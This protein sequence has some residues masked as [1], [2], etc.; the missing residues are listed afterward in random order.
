MN[1]REVAEYLRLKERKIYDLVA[2][3]RI[4]CTRAAGKWLFPRELID[5]WL[6]QQAEGVPEPAAVTDPPPIVGGSHDPLLEWAVRE[7]GSGLAV[8]FDGSLDGLERLLR[9]EVS[10]CGLHVPDPEG[11]GHNSALLDQRAATEPLVAIEWARRW[12]GLIVAPGNPL[13]IR[14]LTD[15]A[16]RRFALRQREAGSHLLLDRLLREA[17]LSKAD[18]SACVGPLRSETELARAIAAG[19]ADAG[20]GIGAAARPLALDFIPLV[21][22]RYDLLIWR[23]QYFEPPIQTLL[24]FCR[25]GAFHRRVRQLDGYDISALGT[26]RFNG[27]G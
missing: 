5:L 23:R 16:G 26:V 20:L 25:D 3:R 24:R 18:F 17:G 21:E 13:G 9:R 11:D 19:E 6:L 15:L 8:L 14:E 12:Q 10:A 4:P 22:E 2:R 27:R 1:T 7:S